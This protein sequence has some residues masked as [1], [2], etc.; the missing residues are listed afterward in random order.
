M[1][2]VFWTY[3]YSPAYDEAGA[4]RGVLVICTETTGRVLAVRRLAALAR[5]AL[6]LSRATQHLAVLDA[7]RAR[8][9]VIRRRGLAAAA[10]A[11]SPTGCAEAVRRR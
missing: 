2:E 1:E 6:N 11:A 7:I 4:I 3:S 10:V 8:D 5:L 9:F